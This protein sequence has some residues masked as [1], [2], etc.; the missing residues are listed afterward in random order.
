MAIVDADEV[1][2]CEVHKHPFGIITFYIQ[3]AIGMTLAAG[4]SYILLPSII[5]NTDDAIFFANVFAA[6]AVLIAFTIVVV[7]T[8]V[9][10]Q[11]RLIVTDR[12]ITQVLQGGL[13]TR[14]TSQLNLYNV[15]D[16]TAAENGFLSTILG[17]GTLTIETAGEQA[18]FRFTY[19]PRPGYYAKIILDSREKLL[20][21]VK[22]MSIEEK[23]RSVKDIGKEI[24]DRSS[25]NDDSSNTLLNN[26]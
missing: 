17:F 6:F 19:C 9:Y 13:F 7:A 3:I 14:K 10:K 2:L 26:R 24:L 8:F 4:L 1:K 18:N 5:E 23:R 20:G 15:E 22:K 21:Q 11:N 25:S 12:N 16:V